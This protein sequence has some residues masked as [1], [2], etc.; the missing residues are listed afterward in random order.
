MTTSAK[1]RRRHARIPI[2]ADYQLTLDGKGYAGKVSNISLSGAFLIMP[3]PN[4]TAT[5]TNKIAGLNIKINDET[6][7]LKCEIVYVEAAGQSVFPAGIGVAFCHDERT[8]TTLWDLA[9]AQG[10]VQKEFFEVSEKQSGN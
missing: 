1:N 2:N 10:I 7:D 6:V 5:D 9:V 8:A 3:E 4:L